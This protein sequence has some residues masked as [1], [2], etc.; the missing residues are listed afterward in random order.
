MYQW[1][2]MFYY[3]LNLYKYISSAYISAYVIV[4]CFRFV[5][6]FAFNNNKTAS[7]PAY[8]LSGGN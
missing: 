8:A 1:I 5:S 2:Y 4:F 7:I 3:F 6:F